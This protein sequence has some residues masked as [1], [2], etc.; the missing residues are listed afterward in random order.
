MNF[1][2]CVSNISLTNT[3]QEQSDSL[4]YYTYSSCLKLRNHYSFSGCPKL[5]FQF[6]FLEHNWC[7]KSDNSKQ[8]LF[9]T[10]HYINISV[11]LKKRES[12][13][14]LLIWAIDA[15]GSGIEV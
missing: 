4:E 6:P 8:I 14:R 9:L 5:R 1:F 13:T 3:R 11:S 15:I 2:K 12:Q 10:I 7:T